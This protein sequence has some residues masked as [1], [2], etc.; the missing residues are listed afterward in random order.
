MSFK[1]SAMRSQRSSFGVR[2]PRSHRAQ[3]LRLTPTAAAASRKVSLRF[4]RQYRMFLP[5]R[6]MLGLY[7]IGTSVKCPKRG[8]ALLRLTRLAVGR[9]VGEGAKGRM[10]W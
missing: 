2:S 4:R 5:I 7:H 8:G 6:D 3:V 1:V 10:T 9:R